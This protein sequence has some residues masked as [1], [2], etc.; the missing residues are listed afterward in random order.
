MEM[1]EFPCAATGRR[2]LP[3]GRRGDLRH[4]R[5]LQPDGQ[6]R[7]GVVTTRLSGKVALITGAA[8]GQGRA[9]AQ[10]LSA[11][12]ADVI[13]ID[14][15]GPLGCRP[16]L[17]SSLPAE[18]ENAHLMHK[19]CFLRAASLVFYGR[20]PSCAAWLDVFIGRASCSGRFFKDL[21]EDD[22]DSRGKL[23]KLRECIQGELRGQLGRTKRDFRLWQSTNRNEA[24]RLM[25]GA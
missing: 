24:R 18:G 6:D 13:L 5:A 1:P 15:A 23:S 11:E 14:I 4:A 10:P 25:G 9:H 2:A 21:R 12:G 16:G 17:A 8:R 22:E 19:E 20:Q 3:M 7:P